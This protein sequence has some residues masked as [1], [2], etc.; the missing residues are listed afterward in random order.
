M[1]IPLKIKQKKEGIYLDLDD[2]SFDDNCEIN[3]VPI[4]KKR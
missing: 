2:A 3:L 1:D 4:R